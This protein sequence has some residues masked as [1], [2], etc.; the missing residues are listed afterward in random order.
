[1]LAPFGDDE[2]SRYWRGDPAMNSMGAAISVLGALEHC[3]IAINDEHRSDVK[4]FPLVFGPRL[5]IRERRPRFF[6]RLMSDKMRELRGRPRN[7]VV[8]ALVG[9][10]FKVEVTTN[11][12]REWVR[13]WRG[14]WDRSAS[15][16]DQCRGS[17]RRIGS[18]PIAA[19]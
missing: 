14:D 17:E 2:W 3:F 7:D 15:R 8:A 13:N 19:A 9:V 6:A 12:V 10:V 4:R 11:I 1:V 18:A 16:R 5:G